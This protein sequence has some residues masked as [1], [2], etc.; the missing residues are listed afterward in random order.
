MPA[1]FMEQRRWSSPQSS[2]VPSADGV[3]ANATPTVGEVG[4]LC[5]DDIIP[6]FTEKSFERG[7]NYYKSGMIERVVRRGDRLFAE[8]WGSEMDDLYAVS[9]ALKGRD[10][11]ASCSCP[12]NW[13]GYCKHI[14]AV[15]LKFIHGGDAFEDGGEPIEDI[16]TRLDAER[17]RALALRMIESHPDLVETLDD[18]AGAAMRRSG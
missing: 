14:A 6:K 13:G 3:G 5:V 16:L 2:T 8:V 10:F 4:E 1:K 17:L 7:V 12:Y 15:T 11:S 9:V 18:F